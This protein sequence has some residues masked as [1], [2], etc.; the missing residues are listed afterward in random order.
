MYTRSARLRAFTAL[1][2]GTAGLDHIT[3]ESE[4]LITADGSALI[5]AAGQTADQE[6]KPC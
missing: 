5:L 3:P 1:L 4:D 2:E 6:Q